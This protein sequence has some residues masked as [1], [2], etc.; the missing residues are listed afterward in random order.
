LGGVDPS[1]VLAG[2]AATGLSMMSLVSLS[3]LCSVYARKPRTAIVGTYLVILGYLSAAGLM[4]GLAA[5]F[6]GFAN[7]AVLGRLTPLTVDDLVFALNAGNIFRTSYRLL[8][9]MGSGSS[10]SSEVP[11]LLRNY[12][13]FHVSLTV[14]CAVWAVSRLRALA[15][16]EMRASGGVS[17]RALVRLR[18]RPSVS[19]SP[20]VWKEVFA[21]PRLQLNWLGRIACTLLVILS[22]VPP[23]WIA[24]YYWLDGP[25]HWR[26]NEISEAMNW[27]VRIAG[28]VVSCLT[29]L[30]VAV[31]ASGAVGG[32]RD[33]QTLDSLLTSPLDSSEIL[34]GKLIGSVCSVRWGW[35]WLATIWALGLVSGGLSPVAVPLLVVAWLTYATFLAILGLW[36]SCACRTTL[37]ANVGTL[38]AAVAAAVGHWLPWITC[39]VPLF[40]SAGPGLD[41]SWIAQFQAL[42]LTPPL[43][44][45]YLAF[46]GSDAYR[47]PEDERFMLFALLGLVCWAT[48]AG[49]LWAATANR[50]RIQAHPTPL[51]PRQPSD[52]NGRIAKPLR[53]QDIAEQ[54]LEPGSPR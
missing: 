13:I 45:G 39:C 52:S 35:L 38:G 8:E 15:L 1:L 24:Y 36:F 22:F 30:G 47:V 19:D 42:A 5:A 41:L 26:G 33:R 37:R 3:I 27:Y 11:G 31:R 46:R 49:L 53:N 18:G 50:F 54:E 17:R 12:A 40:I 9:T 28:T 7:L 29:L 25:L 20:V 6:H 51:A 21:E 16:P 23:A 43:A 2:F 4:T 48:A 10:W 44:L 34:F 32:E 14:L